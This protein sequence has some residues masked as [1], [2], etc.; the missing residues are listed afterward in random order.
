MRK[1]I[2]YSPAGRKP[3]KPRVF[4]SLITVPLQ[5]HNAIAGTLVFYYRNSRAFSEI[6]VRV[7]TAL[8]NLAAAAIGSADLYE[9]ESQ[10]RKL[11]ESNEQRAAFLAEAGQIL[12]SSLDFDRTLA[13]IVELAVPRFADCA[14]VEVL[15]SSG[16]IRRVAL[17][18][19]D[20]A[21]LEFVKDYRLRFPPLEG[22]IA[23]L[24]LHTGTSRLIEDIP[25]EILVQRAR[26]PEHLEALRYFGIKSIIL[27]P[28]IANTRKFGLLTFV[29]AESGRRYSQ[30]DLV[31]AEELA[32]R[33]ASAMDNARHFA[34]STEAQNALRR[35]NAELSR[36]NEDLNQFA[37]SVS[38]DLQEPLRMLIIYSQLLNRRHK[39]LLDDQAGEYLGFIVEG[40][41]RMQMLLSD[42]LAYMQVVNIAQ[43]PKEAVDAN[44]ALKQVLETLAIS[45]SD[46]G[47]TFNCEELPPLAVQEFHLVQLF[48]NLIS[49]AIKYRSERPLHVRV[50]CKRE[51][52]T[53]KICV[54]D[55][56]IGIA[57]EYCDQVFKVFKRLHDKEK[58][59]GTGIGLSICQKIVERYGG[60]IWIESADG[61]GSTVCIELPVT[62]Q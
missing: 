27:A 6:E 52:A 49:N 62:D 13:S 16:E 8:G 34:Q 44:R 47:A 50:S 14:A 17:K 51:G 11:A 39:A 45:I 36:A 28:L 15:D 26:S 53:W 43:L 20:P 37:Y 5:I 25:D 7:A 31:F 32:R 30:A 38:H 29:S 1:T 60:K 4:K 40:A 2:R 35:T 54:E 12:S 22:D 23:R 10:L 9:R 3:T 42:L 19:C 21:K 58:Y 24:A 46:S 59:P 41:K 18:H 61:K 57:P 56:G 48:Q 55:N 33:A